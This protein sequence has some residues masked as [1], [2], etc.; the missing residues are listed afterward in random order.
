[1]STAPVL[2]LLH[3]V[4]R[5]GAA[6]EAVL[7][8]VAVTGLAALSGRELDRAIVLWERVESRARAVKLALVA[9]GS[10]V[11]DRARASGA[12]SSTAWLS[13][14][15]RTD[16][17]AAR[18]TVAEA[19]TLS[20]AASDPVTAGLASD[21]VNGAL[22]VAQAV[23]GAEAV[24]DLPPDL[25]A[26]CRLRAAELVR[27]YAGELSPAGVRT[28]GEQVVRDADPAEGAR[29]LAGRRE[30]ELRRAR[31]RRSL[32]IG[33]PVAGQVYGSFVLPTADASVVR[34]ALRA[35]AAPSAAT[36]DAAGSTRV[37]DRTAEQRMADALVE[38]ARHDLSRGL[39]DSG[40][41]RPQVIVTM[42]WEG[43]RQQTGQAR[44]ADGGAISPSEARRIAC[45]AG[46]VPTVLGAAGEPLD[47][48][49]ATRTVSPAVRRALVL[50]DGG[51]AFPGCSR[52]P[53]WCHAHHVRHWADGGP[54]AV[55][56]LVLLCG[57]HHRTLHA[58][59]WQ[60][61]VSRDGHHRWQPPPD[62]V[63]RPPSAPAGARSGAP[64]GSDRRYPTVQAASWSSARR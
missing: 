32:R 40:G 41:E 1:M 5:S 59:G 48:G 37:D 42:T 24:A 45:D 7:D 58:D 12:P 13:R 60:V 53:S 17:G 51:C 16:P 21:A 63:Q 34:T 33:E 20:A 54:T 23:R 30:D 57:F 4:Q 64:P 28:Y 44:T 15:T 55:G 26:A 29:R 47:V 43:L 18:R 61:T 25:D 10:T 8:G 49:R 50:R 6:V 9:E 52:P 31:Q 27:R 11:R 38:L 19:E 39:P 36:V 3:P 62:R 46:V 22:P 14:L 35:L 2:E 56:N